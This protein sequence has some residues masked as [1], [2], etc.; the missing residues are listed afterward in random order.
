L[1]A[2]YVLIPKLLTPIIDPGEQIEIEIY[3]TGSGE[4]AANKLV[5]ILSSKHLVNHTEPGKIQFSMGI[6]TIDETTGEGFLITGD[7]LTNSGQGSHDLNVTGLTI[8]VSEAYFHK[9]SEDDMPGYL[10]QIYGEGTFDDV[11]P[12]V[13]TINTREKIPKGDYSI[14]MAFTYSDRDSQ[15]M[16]TDHKVVTVHVTDFIEKHSMILSLGAIIGTI[17]SVAGI[18]LPFVITSLTGS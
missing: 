10:N 1:K 8:R 5:I 6:E 2:S 13:L 16:T 17:V 15:E 12:F 4:L 7:E 11:A 3:L 9:S 18:L 14:D